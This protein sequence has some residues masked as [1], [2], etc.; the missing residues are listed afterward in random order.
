M[1]ISIKPVTIVHF[2]LTSSSSQKIF[3]GA[4]TEKHQWVHFRAA[5]MKTFLHI[6]SD[7]R[8][9]VNY[10]LAYP[11]ATNRDLGDR[12]VRAVAEVMQSSESHKCSL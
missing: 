2:C 8:E 6:L 3:A 12:S 10:E 11:C 5:Q 1:C 4:S 7:V 9:L